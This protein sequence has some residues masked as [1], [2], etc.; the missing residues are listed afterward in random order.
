[1]EK[2]VEKILDLIEENPRVTQEE[3]SKKIGLTRRG[4]EW[5][6]NNLKKQGILKR[7]GGKKG[8]HWKLKNLK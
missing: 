3:I 7:I 6:M 8:G 1:M 2:T 5:N 4:V